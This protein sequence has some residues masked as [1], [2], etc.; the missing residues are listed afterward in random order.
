MVRHQRR[1]QEVRQPQAARRSEPIETVVGDRRLDRSVFAAPLG[2]QPVEPDRIDHRA[3]ENV[4]A[5]L[6]ALFDDDH[7]ELGIDLLEADR[8]GQ[9]AGPAPTMTTSNSIASRAGTSV[10]LMR[11]YPHR[12]AQVS[13]GTLEVF[14]DFRRGDNRAAMARRERLVGRAG[15]GREQLFAGDLMAWRS[16]L[17]ALVR[18]EPVDERRCRGRV[19]M[20]ML[21]R[22]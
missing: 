14:H 22:H 17:P 19:H 12:R 8:R 15:L 3:G 2:Q 18:H 9:P 10:S 13:R 21:R 5:D 16:T 11:G 7:A 4:R 6:G 1:Q 20:R